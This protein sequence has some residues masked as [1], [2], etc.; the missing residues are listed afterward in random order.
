MVLVA[1]LALAGCTDMKDQ[2][3]YEP[4]EASAFFSNGQSSRTFPEGTVARGHL[5]D[6]DLLYRGLGPDGQFA[7]TF[8]MPVTSELLERGQQRFNIF[9]TPCHDRTG[10]GNGMIVQRGYKKPPSFHEPRLRSS[11]HGYFFDVITHGFNT[12]QSYAAQI[13]PRDRWAI[14]A[15]LRALQLSE[16]VDVRTIPAAIQAQLSHQDVVDT[17]SPEPQQEEDHDHGH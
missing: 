12:M 11:A 15:Y 1:G 7:T 9:C 3:R 10:H 13:P 14:I 2:P 4:L 16:D 6:D 5:D 17:R 8:P